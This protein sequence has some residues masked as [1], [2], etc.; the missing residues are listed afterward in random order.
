M[1][2]RIQIPSV[3]SYLDQI[4]KIRNSDNLKN[5]K[6]HPL[7]GKSRDLAE[8]HP[9]HT[10]AATAVGA[11]A[12]AGLA[13]GLAVGGS[14]QP[15]DQFGHASAVSKVAARHVSGDSQSHVV[16]RTMQKTTDSGTPRHQAPARHPAPS[17]PAKPYLMY[18]SVT[19]SSIPSG[20]VA[21][22]Y[23]TG[24]FAAS[25]SQ[26]GSHPGVVWIDTNGSDPKASA[27]DVEPGDATPSQAAG[28][29]KSRLSANPNAVAR[30]YTMRSEWGAVK[31]A[32]AGLPEKMQAHVRWWIADPTGQQ[33]MVPGAAATQW[34]W[35][36]HYD[37]TTASPRF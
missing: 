36:S 15:A 25:P 4:R 14:G 12:V 9:R 35:G 18:D 37:I 31:S 13:T 22:V 23:A 11:V 29:A 17:G 16:T 32:V 3:Q 28:W 26:V 5:L 20:R 34:Y 7:V 30:I 1:Y 21:A 24:G 19:P 6:N 27:L 2:P 33:H 8:R 10:L